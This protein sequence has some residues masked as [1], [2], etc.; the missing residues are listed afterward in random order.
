MSRSFRPLVPFFQAPALT[1]ASKWAGAAA[2]SGIG[3]L[4][5]AWNKADCDGPATPK[6][7]ESHGEAMLG[8]C[9]DN[10]FEHVECV[11]SMPLEGSVGREK[12][13]V[14]RVLEALQS[15]MW[16]NIVRATAAPP[17]A[18]TAVSSS[19][20]A[21]SSSLEKA[22]EK[23]GAYDVLNP[24]DEAAKALLEAEEKE[25][26]GLM[27]TTTK[28]G[29]GDDDDGAFAGESDDAAKALMA[30]MAASPQEGGSKKT[31]GAASAAAAKGKGKP[32]PSAA[33]LEDIDKD[34]GR[35]F[36]EV[37]AVRDAAKS[38]KMT[39]EQRREAAAQATMRLMAMFGGMGMGMG[40]EDEDEEEEAAQA[41]P[42]AAT[43]KQQSS[44]KT[45]GNAG[46]GSKK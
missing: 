2:D 35:I 5:C 32:G 9:L 23:E 44:S 46:A 10:G 14:A 4:L 24:H 7:K 22:A 40:D 16:S 18:S 11:A 27:K 20:S 43:S 15:T 37:K 12:S 25:A 29:D 19:S 33:A 3:C 28:A 41:A 17:S 36:E 34:F 6:E 1:V 38:G 31:T 42:A 45:K 39:D 8:W 30:A 21:A 13:S 26:E